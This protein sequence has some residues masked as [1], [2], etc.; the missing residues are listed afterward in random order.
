[1]EKLAAIMRENGIEPDITTLAFTLGYQAGEAMKKNCPCKK[2]KCCR[3]KK[4]TSLSEKSKSQI[5]IGGKDYTFYSLK[6]LD[7]ERT[8]HL[9]YSIRVLLESNLRNYD[10]FTVKGKKTHP[11]MT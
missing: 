7:D 9:P 8:K 6:K 5:S 2:K 3:G 1:M 10:N 11:Q 4:T